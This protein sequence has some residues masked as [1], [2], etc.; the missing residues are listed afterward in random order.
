M[1]DQWIPSLVQ[2]PGAIKI[3][4]LCREMRLHTLSKG[5]TNQ[6]MT[7]ATLNSVLGDKK[8]KIG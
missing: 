2:L 7:Q 3:S 5:P 8:F 1:R 6:A 4:A